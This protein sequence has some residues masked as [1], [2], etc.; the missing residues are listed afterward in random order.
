M[1]NFQT[2][3][4]YRP[5]HKSLRKSKKIFFMLKQQ[6]LKEAK[7]LSENDYDLLKNLLIDLEKE[8][9]HKNKEAAFSLREQAL[10]KAELLMPKNFTHFFKEIVF[11]LGS[12]LLLVALINQ[13]WFQNYQIPT[14]S[15]RPTLMEKDRLIALKTNFGI[16]FP[17]KGGH[18]LFNPSQLKRGNIVILQNPRLPKAENQSRYLFIFPAQKQFVKRLIGKPGDVI[19]FYGG[20]IYGLDRHNQEITEFHNSSAFAP[21]EHV[22]FNSFEGNLKMEPTLSST[23]QNKKALYLYQMDQLVGK[24]SLKSNYTTLGQFYNGSQ[25]VNES[26]N[27]GYQDLWGIKNYGMARILSKKQV[28]DLAL[29]SDLSSADYYLEIAHSPHLTF[30]RP[31]LVTNSY[32]QTYLTPSLQKSYLPLEQTD[33]NKIKEVLSTDRFVIRNEYACNYQLDNSFKKTATSPYFPGVPDGTYEFI[34]GK[35][36]KVLKSGK[37]ELLSASH[38][39]NSYDPALLQKLYNYGIHMTTYFDPSTSSDRFPHRYVYYR[40]GDLF[41]LNQ[42]L[43]KKGNPKLTAFNQIEAQKPHPFK[44]YGPPLNAD[45]TLNKELITNYGLLIPQGHYL[46]LGDNHAGSCDCRTWG[47]IPQKDLQGSPGFIFWPLSKRFGTLEQN[48]M[49][50]NN[51]PTFLVSLMGCLAIVMVFSSNRRLKKKPL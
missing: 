50:W 8:I 36:Y 1:I 30:P 33:L 13:L 22:P 32:G 49:A 20:K 10:A 51:F 23:S 37:Q 14:G 40:E 27:M 48:G 43:L 11:G 42:P 38:P 25:W 2:L 41:V 26:P 24:L 17:F 15:M 3:L 12:V 39:L 7:K 28:E 34:Q 45:G 47:F 35:A 5:F 46:C 31:R 6:L 4:Q 19:Y 18:L 9:Q 21:L 44:D 29:S 16:N